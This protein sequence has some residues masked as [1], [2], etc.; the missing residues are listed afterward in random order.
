MPPSSPPR[1]FHVKLIGRSLRKGGAGLLILHKKKKK[2]KV[3]GVLGGM[4]LLIAILDF[5]SIRTPR[6]PIIYLSLVMVLIV[7]IIQ[8]TLGVLVQQRE[9][10]PFDYMAKQWH[11]S[12]DNYRNH[13]QDEVCSMIY[14]RFVFSLAF[15]CIL[16]SMLRV[17]Q[18]VRRHSD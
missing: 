10:N 11:D 6:K 4:T 9:E 16:V 17:C 2:K 12:G 15:Y 14:P 1:F 5:I 7:L 8:I 18:C 3:C 13:L